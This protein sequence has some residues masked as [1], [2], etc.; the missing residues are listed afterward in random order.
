MAGKP[1]AEKAKLDRSRPFATISSMNSAVAGVY[2]QD[3][4]L[5]NQDGVEMGKTAGY[6]ERVKKAEKKAAKVKKSVALDEA[7]DILGQLGDPNAEALK[8]NAAA[9]AAEELADA[10]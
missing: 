1:K 7:N 9:K 8:E 3:S 4:I 2:E 5:F 10:S 6:E